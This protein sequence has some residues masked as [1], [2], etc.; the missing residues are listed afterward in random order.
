MRNHQEMKRRLKAGNSCYHSAKYSSGLLRIRKL[1]YMKN[2][3]ANCATWLWYMVSYIKGEMQAKG[4]WKNGSWGE[5]LGQEG[6]EWGVEKAPL[7]GNHSLYGPYNIFRV[8]I[9]ITLRWGEHETRMEESKNV[10]KMFTRKPTEMRSSGELIDD[11]HRIGLCL[12]S[13]CSIRRMP[14]SSAYHRLRVY[15]TY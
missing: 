6:W 4:I 3:I 9:Y 12:L 13:L 15:L 1:K 2:N 7:R 5:Y 14:L 8:T 11:M 10:L